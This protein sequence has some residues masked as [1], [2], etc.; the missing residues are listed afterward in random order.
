[1]LGLRRSRLRV[2]N[3]ETRERGK[4]NESDRSGALPHL[5]NSILVLWFP[6][7]IKVRDGEAPSLR[8]LPDEARALPRGKSLGSAIQLGFARLCRIN[9]SLGLVW[10]RR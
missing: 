1:M 6:N 9:E 4:T 10:G 3:Q 8:Q 2:L 7:S 5:S